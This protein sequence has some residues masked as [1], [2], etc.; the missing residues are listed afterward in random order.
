MAEKWYPLSG[1]KESNICNSML[2]SV[3]ATSSTDPVY[4]I[5][6]MC[7]VCAKPGIFRHTGFRS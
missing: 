6:R 4:I 2:N 5:S 1:G 7:G 3:L